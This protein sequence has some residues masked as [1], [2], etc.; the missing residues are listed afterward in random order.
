M[1]H[2]A[3]CAHFH[4]HIQ[5][6]LYC[7][8]LASIFLIITTPSMVRHLFFPTTNA[9]IIQQ[10][11]KL[12]RNLINEKNFSQWWN[13]SEKN[14]WKKICD[15]RMTC[16]AIDIASQVSVSD[17]NSFLSIRIERFEIQYD[18]CSPLYFFNFFNYFSY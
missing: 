5:L 7:S 12:L 11:L 13:F 4:S 14:N 3:F 18:I 1:L 15:L 8:K 6:N 2:S 10:S 17:W 9:P 16:D